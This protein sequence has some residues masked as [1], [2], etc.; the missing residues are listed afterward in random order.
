MAVQ[1]IPVI[2]GQRVSDLAPRA[3]EHRVSVRCEAE[4][5]ERCSGRR[6][7]AE[8]RKVACE[9]RCHGWVIPDYAGESGH[10]QESDWF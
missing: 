2:N 6:V 7:D 10:E 9:H 4:A 1:R 3:L 8:G 5:C